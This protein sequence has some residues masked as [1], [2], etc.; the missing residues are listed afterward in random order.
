MNTLKK[1]FEINLKK[2][3]N[4][5]DSNMKNFALN[6]DKNFNF[7]SGIIIDIREKENEMYKKF[8]KKSEE[9]FKSIISDLEKICERIYQY[10]NSLNVFDKQNDLLKKNIAES[11]TAVKTRLDVHKINQKILYTIEN[12][13]M[14]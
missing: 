3:D 11:L 10:E 6:I 12:D 5:L 7:I 13:L 1:Y 8:Q 4:F 14:Q 2:H 9:K